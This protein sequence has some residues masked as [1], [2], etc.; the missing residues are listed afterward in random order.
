[1]HLTLRC[2]LVVLVI[3]LT[4][5]A[6]PARAGQVSA[7]DASAGGGSDLWQWTHEAGGS[8][9]AHIFDGGPVD[10]KMILAG[11][12]GKAQDGTPLLVRMTYSLQ[13]DGS[14]RQHGQASKDQGLTWV[15]HFDLIYRRKE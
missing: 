1:M 12:W 2:T 9:W 10:G 8:G 3:G 7:W 14:V 13:N 15:D 6:P 5:V 4:F 11:Y